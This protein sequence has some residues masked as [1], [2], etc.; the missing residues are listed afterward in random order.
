[1]EMPDKYSK[2][3]FRNALLLSKYTQKTIGRHQ[4]FLSG[5]E[6]KNNI[7]TSRMFQ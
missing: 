2:T 7:D 4:N 3:V 6:V 1:M 5:I